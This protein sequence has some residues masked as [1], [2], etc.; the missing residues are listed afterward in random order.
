MSHHNGRLLIT[1]G[2]SYLGQHLVPLALEAYDVCY[3]FYQN[4]P[5]QLAQGYTLDVRDETAVIQLVKAFRP[6]FIIHTV[7]SNRA[8]DMENVIQA[9]TVHIV[10]AATLANARLIHVSTDSIFNGR[11][12]PYDETAPPSPVNNYG[13]AKATAEAM[14]AKYDNHVIIRTSLIYG[15]QLMDQGTTWMANALRAGESVTLF[16]N[17]RRNPV[18]AETLSRACLELLTHHYTGILNVA[19]QQ[20]MSRAAFALRMLDW[21]GITERETLT[22]GPSQSGK[23]PLDCELNVSRAAALLSVPLFGVDEVLDLSRAKPLEC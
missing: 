13:R 4:D 15:L 1:G 18:W 2:S 14:V 19:G 20:V 8:A 23:W 12:P 16:S 21:W 17:Q 3:T 22:I 10:Q 6:H 5:L 7:G 9:G 11:H